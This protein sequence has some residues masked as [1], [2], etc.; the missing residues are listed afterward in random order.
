MACNMVFG[1]T[2][3]FLASWVRTVILFFWTG[4]G[5]RGLEHAVEPA[6]LDVMEG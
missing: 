3:Y 5:G 4:S 6:G 2:H 1:K